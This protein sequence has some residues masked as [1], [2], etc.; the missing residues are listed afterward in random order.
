VAKDAVALQQKYPD[1]RICGD[2]SGSLSN[3]HERI[4][5]LDDRGNP[6]DDVHYYEGGRWPV[7]ADGGGSSLELRNPW[8]D[9]AS[10]EAWEAS[11]EDHRSQWRHY[12]YTGV[13]QKPVYEPAIHFHEFVMGLLDEGQVLLDNIS[14]IENP[15]TDPVELIQN[16]T[17]EAD[18]ID[19]LPEK[20]RIQGTHERSRIIHDPDNPQN[21]VLHLVADGPTNYLCNHAETTLAGG[22][23]VV[24][25]REYMI[26]YDAKWI[27]GSPQLRTELYYND[28]PKTTI[29]DMPAL[30]GTPGRQNSTF[31]TN[32]GPTYDDLAQYPIV[33]S[34]QE[35]V[36]V[37]VRANDPDGIASLTL[38]FALDGSP[39]WDALAMTKGTADVYS[40][41][42]PAQSHGTVV[43]FYVEGQDAQGALSCYP[44]AG[45]GTR[46][47]FMADD[48]ASNRNTPDERQEIRLIMTSA[49]TSWALRSSTMGERSST[50][51]AFDYGAVCS[52]A[53]IRA[54]SD[55][56]SAFNRTTCFGVYTRVSLP[57]RDPRKRYWPNI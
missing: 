5:L 36:S 26:S 19:S 42:I 31:E 13:A 25:G 49:D 15:Y 8:A 41:T 11:M 55:T 47:L 6:A 45:P 33:P 29:L 21:K 48:S 50:M 34:S 28:V 57:G 43:Q 12:S 44:A 2:Y 9:N 38:W 17:F 46:V 27:A 18:Q 39:P 53:R 37:S 23:T 7:F 14:V 1:I 56:I 35:D 52:A 20:W 24:D 22:R 3:E 51:C 30:A 10:A 54:D 32:I 16:G 4:V 40:A